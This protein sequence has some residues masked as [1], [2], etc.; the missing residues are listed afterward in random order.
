M[1]CFKSID[2]NVSRRRLALL[3]TSLALKYSQEWFPSY[4]FLW[5][6]MP[7]ADN[8]QAIDHYPWQWPGN[9]LKKTQLPAKFAKAPC[10]KE[11]MV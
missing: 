9:D 6:S 10:I 5:R 11:N 3:Y 8:C 1:K 4:S 2:Y 7:S